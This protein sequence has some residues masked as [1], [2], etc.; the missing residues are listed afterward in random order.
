MGSGTTFKASLFKSKAGEKGHEQIDQTS[1]EPPLKRFG[2]KFKSHFLLPKK[3]LDDSPKINFQFY[4]FIKRYVIN[5]YTQTERKLS[6]Q[7]F[8]PK[9]YIDKFWRWS[10]GLVGKVVQPYSSKAIFSFSLDLKIYILALFVYNNN[11]IL[12]WN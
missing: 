1:F 5:F 4:R 12:E 6:A 7:F 8:S 3:K 10:M 2:S 11:N 9:I